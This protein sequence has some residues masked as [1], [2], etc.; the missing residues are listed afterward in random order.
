MI[1]S[2]CHSIKFSNKK[3]KELIY[4]FINNYKQMVEKYGQ[5]D[6]S[7]WLKSIG[8]SDSNI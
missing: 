7:W 5:E 8:E 2:S 1:R 4:N 3:K 6:Y